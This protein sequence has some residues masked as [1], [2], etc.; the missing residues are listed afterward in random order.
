MKRVTSCSTAAWTIAPVSALLTSV[1][2]N[3]SLWKLAIPPTIAARWM[4]C[5]HPAS[6][7]RATSRSRR[8]P[9]CSS[10]PSRIQA[11]AGRWSATRTSIVRVAQQAAHDR[12]ADRAGSARDQHA[13]HQWAASGEASMPAE[14]PS[15]AADSAANRNTCPVPRLFHGSASRQSSAASARIWRSVSGCSNCGV[16]GRH[17]HDVG[18]AHRLVQ[19][20]GGRGRVGVADRD[21]GQLALEHADELV[22]QRVAL[23]V[24]VALEG[25]A[26]HRHLAAGQAPDAALDPLDQE[27][28]HALV[29]ARDGQ[30]HAGG[31]RALLREREVLAQAGPGR[32]ARHRDAAAGVVVVDQVDDLEHVGPVALAVHHQQVGQRERGVAQDV[33]PDLGQLR[34]HGR[35]LDDRRAEHAEQVGR[36]LGGALADA[37]DDARQRGDLLAGTFR[38]RS[39]PG[40]GRRTR[41]RRRAGRGASRGSRRR[42]RSSRAR[43]WS[44]GSAR[45]RAAAAAGGRRPPRA[46]GAG[47]TPRARTRASRW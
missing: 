14:S 9:R 15:R 12:R 34:L 30:Q 8:S 39:A 37:A 11:G 47:R 21:V 13:R 25:Q 33:G 45:D 16:V 4:T 46:P 29:D 24:G 19:A 1:S 5:E 6:A 2:V 36:V 27:Q 26:E 41:P 28:R 18:I 32:H 31:V 42:T 23:V 7:P 44:A 35:G 43:S 17:D 40:R 20:L 10:Q 3:G 38:R 22:R